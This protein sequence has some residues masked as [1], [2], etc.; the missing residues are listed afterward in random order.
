[1]F[2][3]MVSVMVC[4]FFLAWDRLHIQF[5]ESFLTHGSEQQV[6]DIVGDFIQ[7]CTDT[8]DV[9][10][11]EAAAKCKDNKVCVC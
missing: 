6:F 7:N 2:V 5:L 11:G 8:L 9:L 1:M 3:F 10:Q 4:L